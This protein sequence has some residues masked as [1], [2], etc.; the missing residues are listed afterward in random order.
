ML[1]QRPTEGPDVLRSRVNVLL[2]VNTTNRSSKISG[3]SNKATTGGLRDKARNKR[4]T[5]NPR[6]CRRRRTLRLCVCLA[7][8][9]T[10]RYHQT[11]ARRDQGDTISH[12]TKPRANARDRDGI[13]RGRDKSTR[14]RGNSTRDRDNS[15]RGRDNSSN[16][17]TTMDTATPF[18]FQ[19]IA[20]SLRLLLPTSTSLGTK[21]LALAQAIT[22]IADT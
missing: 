11:P 22:T 20:I 19:A 6:R 13:T 12:T 2:Q 18:R 7:S 10:R 1:I 16:P 8:V 3:I 17:I 5:V 14:D 15:T 21:M 9:V 4:F